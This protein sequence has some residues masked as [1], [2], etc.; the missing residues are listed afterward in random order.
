MAPFLRARAPGALMVG[1]V[2]TYLVMHEI[3]RKE[4]EELMRSA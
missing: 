1:G 3:F 4:T 2:I